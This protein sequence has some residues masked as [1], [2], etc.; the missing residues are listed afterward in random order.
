M[1]RPLPFVVLS[2]L[3]LALGVAG[4]AFAQ[5]DGRLSDEWE[6]MGE[7]TIDDEGASEAPPADPDVTDDQKEWAVAEAPDEEHA[8]TMH[9]VS[10]G[11]S[12]GLLA[13]VGTGVGAAV[14]I[15]HGA[16]WTLAP[17]APDIVIWLGFFAFPLAGAAGGAVAG[18]L[19]FNEPAYL[20]VTSGAAAAGA[21]L[22]ALIGWGV[23]AAFALTSPPAPFP[24]ESESTFKIAAGIIG[25]AAVG[26]GLG[27]AIAAPFMAAK[28]W[29]EGSMGADSAKPI[30]NDAGQGASEA[31]EADESA[32]SWAD[33]VE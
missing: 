22:G 4:P 32:D 6:D 31:D 12:A 1:T 14:A 24:S 5:D 20:A 7:A 30:S 3:L 16:L 10:A 17:N 26:A 29:E 19:P 2:P 27:A 8:R 9:L 18:G 13:F 28:P 23:G 15:S 25:G 11:A 21:G 33:E